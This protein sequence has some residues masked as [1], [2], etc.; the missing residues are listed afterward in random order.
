MVVSDLLWGDHQ[1]LRLKN[2]PDFLREAH[3]RDEAFN[4]RMIFRA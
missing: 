3:L 2:L 4:K 1:A